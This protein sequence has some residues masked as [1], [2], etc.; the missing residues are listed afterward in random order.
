MQPIWSLLNS[1]K[2][3]LEW[4]ST[5][6]SGL[7]SVLAGRQFPQS[8]CFAAGWTSHNK[9]IACLQTIV[10][11][12][13]T[14]WQRQSRIEILEQ[15][16]KE[17]KLT[18][19]ATQRQ[20]EKA[21][22]GNLH[23]RAWMCKHLEPDRKKYASY[24][25]RSRTSLGWGSGLAS[26]ERGLMPKP[27]PPPRPPAAE[28]T[29]HWHVKPQEDLLCAT[30]Y[31]DGSALDGPSEDLRRCGW[32]FVA[33]D[34][35]GV[36]L[37]AAYGATP[38]WIGDICGAEGWALLQAT[39]SAF[40]GACRFI[41]DC[42]VMVDLILGGSRKAVAAGSTHARV[43]ALILA[44]L[45]DTPL[46]KVIWMPAHQPM[47]AAGVKAKG[48]NEPL[49]ELD[50]EGNDQADKLAKRGV[51]DHR[52]PY[53]VREEWRRCMEECKARAMWIAR[54]TV[55]ANNLPSFPFSDSGSSRAMADKA[56][57]ERLRKKEVGSKKRAAN[58]FE[59]PVELGGHTLVPV[60][61]DGV[62]TEWR[63]TTCRT[64]SGQWE[65]LAPKTCEGSKVEEWARRAVQAAEDE[66]II[67][68]GHR[69]ALSGEVVWCQVCGCYSD[70]RV[71]GLTDYCKGKPT[72]K[73]GGGRAGQLLYLRNNIHPRT[74]KAL[75]APVDEHGSDLGGQH[76][77]SQLARR[78]AGVSDAST[79]S[80]QRE[81]GNEA[82][83]LEAGNGNNRSSSQYVGK[84][85]TEKHRERLERIRAK[86]V[87]NKASDVPRRL[88]GKQRPKEKGQEPCNGCPTWHGMW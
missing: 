40:P 64:R 53:R 7:G 84:T 46:E 31:L 77:Y 38:P 43:Y 83:E 75:P 12:E 26:W 17:A 52:V 69:R 37:A 34:E 73:S 60:V 68:A 80:S 22:V 19:T 74:R 11:E 3:D 70:S 21:P 63:C 61:R 48:N 35:E 56:K 58:M 79:S 5:L 72:D 15:E 41:S 16:G 50:I 25:D 81:V 87:A 55:L 36:V 44:A 42:K 47:S 14:D 30:F 4:N 45:D 6:R 32:S 76:V 27:P 54:A 57:A 24:R 67:G 20:I 10:E 39:G 29:F 13:E 86:E 59:R 18:V 66:Q 9:C 51:E 1:R 65:Q 23:H 82:A 62:C 85:A 28:A 2:D 78:N 8:R 88:R 71:R 49:T 33:V